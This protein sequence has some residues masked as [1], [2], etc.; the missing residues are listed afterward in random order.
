MDWIDFEESGYII[1]SKQNELA[2]DDPTK[3][4]EE[5]ALLLHS[6]T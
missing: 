2:A 3:S 1:V 5:L 6:L 4:G